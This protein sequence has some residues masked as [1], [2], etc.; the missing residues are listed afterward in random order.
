VRGSDKGSPGGGP[1]SRDRTCKPESTS[2]R[3][4]ERFSN[5]RETLELIAKL[6]V[7]GG[8]ERHLVDLVVLALNA[9]H[10][11]PPLDE[12]AVRGIVETVVRILR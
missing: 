8:I 2:S 5:P 12:E 6:L 7:K 11:D 4:V 1:G 3:P 9:R 10:C